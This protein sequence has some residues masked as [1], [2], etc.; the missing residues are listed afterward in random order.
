MKQAAA[1]AAQQAPVWTPN[2]SAKECKVHLSRIGLPLTGCASL[3]Y[4]PPLRRSDP[5]VDRLS[6]TQHSKM[7]L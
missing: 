5:L 6:T 3:Q 4:D 1:Q 7:L 2:A